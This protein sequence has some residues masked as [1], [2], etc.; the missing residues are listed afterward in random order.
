MPEYTIPHLPDTPMVIA[1]T[2]TGVVIATEI[3]PLA[4]HM[5]FLET[6][7]DA[8]TRGEFPDD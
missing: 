8:A 4:R 7:I 1:E 2:E 5:R 3:N 6:V